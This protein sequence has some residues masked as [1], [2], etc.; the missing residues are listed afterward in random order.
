MH[1]V[2]SPEHAEILKFLSA[3][4]LCLFITGDTMT[5]LSGSE[6]PN[7]NRAMS[8]ETLRVCAG[9]KQAPFRVKQ[10]P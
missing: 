4:S 1:V 6:T 7:T 5:S 8:R 9:T 2:F 10:Q 3:P